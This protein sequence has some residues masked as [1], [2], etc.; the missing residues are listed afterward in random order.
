MQV[1]ESSD[2][3]VVA[4]FDAHQTN[5][6]IKK[7]DEYSAIEALVHR[8]LSQAGVGSY[9]VLPGADV[10]VVSLESLGGGARVLA[11]GPLVGEPMKVPGLGAF[12][13]LNVE[14]DVD[15]REALL[16]WDGSG[17]QMAT[18]EV[19][20]VF[21][22]VRDACRVSCLDAIAPQARALDEAV[23]AATRYRNA[24]WREEESIVGGG[25][26]GF[27]VSL[28][29]Q[30]ADGRRRD[31]LRA[32]VALSPERRANVIRAVFG[33]RG[34]TVALGVVS[35]Q[36]INEC[37]W[38][39]MSRVACDRRALEA[40]LAGLGVSVKVVLRDGSVEA[41]LDG[42]KLLLE[43]GGLIDVVCSGATQVD[44]LKQ[45]LETVAG[46][47]VKAIA[48]GEVVRVPVWGEQLFKAQYAS[49]DLDLDVDELE[50]GDASLVC[51]RQRQ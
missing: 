38:G 45:L 1:L 33:E 43:G 37:L 42:G 29:V 30:V 19:N 41:S 14:R 6:A 21:A 49:I 26:S 48:C 8:V 50:S 3:F 27:C 32:L 10:F 15:L 31:M 24:A 46:A 39:Q 36:E 22:L 25:G 18:R 4:T 7:V 16:R 34:E 11:Y 9:V 23:V 35:E 12:K 47:Q 28:M 51:D 13:L 17:V 20:Q 5:D 44:A 40:L 2:G